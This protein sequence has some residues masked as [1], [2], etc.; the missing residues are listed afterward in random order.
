[1]WKGLCLRGPKE[2]KID[3]LA[4]TFGLLK[5]NMALLARINSL[6]S[7]IV[8]TRHNLTSMPTRMVKLKD[9]V[10][11]VKGGG[12]MATG[13]AQRIQVRRQKKEEK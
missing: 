7:L 13:V 10:V 11:L 5:V 2:G 1:M 4:K 3:F 9:L 6:G 12:E 8:S